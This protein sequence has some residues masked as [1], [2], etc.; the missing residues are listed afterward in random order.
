M[1]QTCAHIFSSI[2]IS[3][4]VGTSLVQSQVR[5]LP[6]ERLVFSGNETERCLKCHGMQ[7]FAFRLPE[8]DRDRI[9]NLTVIADTFKTSVHKNVSCQHCHTEITE[10]PHQFVGARTKVSC[11]TDCHALDSTGKAYT[12]AAVYEDFRISVHRK[13]LTDST[14]GNPNCESCHGA[15]NP[16]AIHR[17]RNSITKADRMNLCIP[18]HDNRELMLANHVDPEA[19]SSY[20]K[21]FHFKAIRFGQ[22]NTATCQDCHSVHRILPADSSGSTIAPAT[23]ARTCGQENC[24]PGVNLNFAM[25]GANHL[26]LRIEKSPLLFIEEELFILLTVGTMAM[27]VVG[28]ILDVQKKFGWIELLVALFGRVRGWLGDLHL[29]GAKALTLARRVLID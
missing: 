23:I 11:G 19:V 10:Y 4:L 9:R 7:N 20:R 3:I 6:S 25:S 24:H 22:T 14:S 18:C 16:H 13:G 21:S 29:V 28:I 2:T 15:G 1:K 26:N 5:E 17:A 27:L 8:K 12:H